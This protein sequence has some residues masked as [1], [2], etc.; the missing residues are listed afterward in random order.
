[1][2]HSST[3]NILDNNF[4][5]Q[6]YLKT[7]PNKPGVYRMLDGEGNVIYV[8]KARDLKKRVT[9]YFRRQNTSLKTVSMVAQVR[10]VEITVTHNEIEA[11]LLENN[12]IKSIKPRYNVLLRDDKSYPYIFLSGHEDF[13]RLGFHRGPKRE[14]GQYF[15]P[16]PSA[17]AARETLYLFQKLF[18]V[19][20]CEDS[21]YR[22]RSRP[23]LQ[24]QIKRCTAPCVGLVDKETYMEDVGHTI[25]LLEGKSN[26]VIDELVKR[27]ESASATLEFERAARY[28]D[29]ISNVRRIQEKQY[30]STDGG[31]LDV[32]AG[33]I[34][35]G[36]GCVQVF[37]I[38]HGRN[39]GN[40]TFFPRHTGHADLEELLSAFITQYYL[41]EVDIGE[42]KREVP[43]EILINHKVEGKN[44]LEQVL[45]QQAG[46]RVGISCPIRG[47]KVRWMALALANA[48][49]ALN[50]HLS[51]KANLLKRFETLQEAMGLDAVPQRIECFDISHTMGE[52]T[53]AS[54]V[55]F[56]INGPV[57]SDYR[58]F[59]IQGITPGDD[60][61]AI[62][63]AL[64]RRFTRI[65][66]G[67]GKLPD[68][69]FIDGGKGQTAQAIQ[70]LQ[71]LQ[72]SGVA[73]VGIAKGPDRKPGLE[74][75]IPADGAPAHLPNDSPALH[76]IQQVRDEAH[77]FAITGHRQRRA[78]ARS[79]SILEDVQGLGAKRRQQLLRQFGGLQEIIRAGV[80]DLAKV[81]G[82]SKQLAQRI[83]DALH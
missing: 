4:D 68:I 40:K 21:F 33:E 3:N 26:Q 13:P 71:E 59:N 19:R 29:Q 5:A 79:K 37:Y 18:P 54:C 23:C 16:Y 49:H 72:I 75:L 56:D 24:Y 2:S 67:E 43:A 58:R 14:K 48:T 61:A 1:M 57:K 31:D 9:S 27:M 47:E 81:Q 76:L 60:Y 45:S 8:G 69:L 80:E 20:Q 77:R 66:E 83:Y 63:Q 51:S 30:I 70:V 64:M 7:L 38:R 39:L 17:S 50:A 53:V 10:S 41:S 32:I 28:R 22:N 74:T 65:K 73:I 11:L 78:K 52:A 46:R 44:L 25:M 12:L 42:S 82:I 15:G 35:N 55:V 34:K 6:A 62:N 36:V